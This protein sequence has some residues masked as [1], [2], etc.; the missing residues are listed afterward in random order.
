MSQNYRKSEFTGKSINTNHLN[1]IEENFLKEQSLKNEH[2]DRFQNKSRNSKN[3]Y[4]NENNENEEVSSE[5]VKRSKEYNKNSFHFINKPN[6]DTNLGVWDEKLNSFNNKSKDSS[7][8][9]NRK[10]SNGFSLYLH[11]NSVDVRNISPEE[12]KIL[13]FEIEKY[14]SLTSTNKRTKSVHFSYRNNF[15]TCKN[16][17][18]NICKNDQIFDLQKNLTSQANINDKFNAQKSKMNEML[19][20]RLN[21]IDNK[22]ILKQQTQNS[23]FSIREIHEPL[24]ENT[25]KKFNTEKKYDC[26]NNK[27]FMDEIR[28]K[29]HVN[30]F[31]DE[32]IMVSNFLEEKHSENDFDKDNLIL[33]DNLHHHDCNKCEENS[34]KSLEWTVG[35]EPSLKCNT[36]SNLSSIYDNSNDYN[37]KKKN[38]IEIKNRENFILIEDK[39]LNE[40]QLKDFMSKKKGE[41][42]YSE[43]EKKLM[44]EQIVFIENHLNFDFRSLVSE[45]YKSAQEKY[46]INEKTSHQNLIEESNNYFV[47]SQK[48]IEK[49][50]SIIKNRKNEVRDVLGTLYENVIYKTQ[51]QIDDKENADKKKEENK[52]EMVKKNVN[53]LIKLAK[54]E[55]KWR[56]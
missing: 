8:E 12:G 26:S 46:I 22:N 17:N 54:I 28:R 23:L 56:E 41:Y 6:A 20:L 44:F 18:F 11:R 7:R 35:S 37:R 55:S 53:K 19:D 2:L 24:S 38:D 29:N 21:L 48:N 40:I 3:R 15:S 5:I 45:L 13:N 39:K 25:N 51:L 42:G 32:K 1:T 52:K 33:L 30:I 47:D 34:E 9:A 36:I 50:F 4:N 49:Q 31:D 27:F 10:S 14:G 43:K 16:D